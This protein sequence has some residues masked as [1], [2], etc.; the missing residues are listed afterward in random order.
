VNK[1][2]L[3]VRAFFA[4]QRAL[5]NMSLALRG[6]VDGF[7]LA[8]LGPASLRAID[9]IYYNDRPKYTDADYNRSGLLDWESDAIARFF[10]SGGRIAVTGAGGGREA[11]ALLRLGYDVDAF[12]CNEQLAAFGTAL[13]EAE[14]HPVAVTTAAPD[15]WPATTG[16]YDGIIVG[17]GSYMLIRGRHQRIAFLRDARRAAADGAPILISFFA[18]G[19]QSLYFRVVRRT[20][21][22][23]RRLRPGPPVEIGDALAPNYVHYFTRQEAEAE[24]AEAGF[25]L[26]FFEREPY[27]RAV[28]IAG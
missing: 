12:E 10:P 4:S 6:V 11:L 2:S 22:L 18:R 23:A 3:A 8:T 1:P 16:L 26:V 15:V 20:G 17:W 7:W 28:G 25:G 14:G 27:G 19:G 13:L 5:E 9:E 21:R 24:L